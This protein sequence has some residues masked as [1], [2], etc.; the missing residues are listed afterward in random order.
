PS[1]ARGPRPAAARPKAPPSPSASSADPDTLHRAYSAMLARLPLHPMHRRDLE[2][3][4]GLAADR[5]DHN[6]Y[7][8]INLNAPE[9]R[10][11][12]K[13]LANE[14]GESVLLKVPGF[15]REWHGNRLVLTLMKVRGLV[16]PRRDVE[17]RINALKVRKDGVTKGKY[18]YFTST[19]A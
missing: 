5:I 13:A 14:I 9:R 16:V 15:Y 6:G 19:F 10:A 17:G 1:G 3:R 8:T 12:A 18:V 4:F 11:L 2:R 7:R